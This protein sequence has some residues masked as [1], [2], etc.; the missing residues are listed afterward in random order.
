MQTINKSRGV[1]TKF[2]EFKNCNKCKKNK[3]YKEYRKVTKAESAAQKKIT[4]LNTLLR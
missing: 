2:V 4:R 3:N 1:P